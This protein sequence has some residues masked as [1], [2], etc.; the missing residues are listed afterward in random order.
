MELSGTYFPYFRGKQYELI[1][2][3]ENAELLAKGSI[4]PII[5][6]VRESL[7]TL[8]K[9][10]GKINAASGSAAIVVNPSFGPFA[11]DRSPLAEFVAERLPPD[12]AVAILLNENTSVEAAITL[13]DEFSPREPLLVHSGFTH[14]RELRLHLDQ[15]PGVAGHV[16]VD[17]TSSKLYRRQFTDAFR[18]LLGD[19]FK[20]RRNADHPEVEPF[21]DLHVTYPDEGFQGFGDFSIVGNEY[22]ES[23]GPAYAVAIHLTYIDP[24]RED[25]MFIR[26]FKSDRSSSPTDPAGKFAEAL[27]KLVGAV[28]ERGSPILKTEAVNEFLSLDRRRHFPGLGYVKKLSMAHHLQTIANYEAQA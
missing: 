17:R 11:D 26:H 15:H 25:E 10:L 28:E 14:A 27:G 8:E 12:F 16:F 23:G 24:D 2:L 4:L 1:C 3:R 21:S 9:A 18:V 20:P 7:G 19:G 22:R 13:Y 6:P 5:E